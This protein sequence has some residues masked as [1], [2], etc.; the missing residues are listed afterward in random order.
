VAIEILAAGSSS[1]LENALT[2]RSN[3][4]A[5]MH[6]GV[7]GLP[8]VSVAQLV[9][10]AHPHAD[11]G[12][13]VAA[14]D[15]EIRRLLTD[16]ADPVEV[17]TAKAQLESG[18]LRRL[19]T[20]AG[21][22]DELAKLALHPGDPTAV[23]RRLDELAAVTIGQV[24]GAARTWLTPEFAADLTYRPQASPQ[25]PDESAEGRVTG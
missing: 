24:D 3:L 11:I 14:A 10:Y 4:A 9:L 1:R 23:N 20:C 19:S 5:S 25:R 7:S 21:R 17:A 13:A 8:A 16:G 6:A 12:P 22:A 18:Q 15:A 2:R